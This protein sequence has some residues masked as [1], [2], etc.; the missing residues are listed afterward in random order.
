MPLTPMPSAAPDGLI[1]FRVG[2][3]LP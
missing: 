2:A 1:I 3:E